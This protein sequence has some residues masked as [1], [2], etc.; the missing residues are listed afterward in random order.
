MAPGRERA[1]WAKVG[2][3]INRPFWFFCGYD[4]RTGPLRPRADE[5]SSLALTQLQSRTTPIKHRNKISFSFEMTIA[6]NSLKQKC[7]FKRSDLSYRRNDINILNSELPN[8]YYA[9]LTCTKCFNW[10]TSFSSRYLQRPR[11]RSF[12]V[13]PA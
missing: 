4:K 10:I 5:V 9:L 8:L 2:I 3:A 7:H 1:L 11:G 12:L 6:K 13:R